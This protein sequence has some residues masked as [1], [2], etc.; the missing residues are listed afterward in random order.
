M[1]SGTYI[2]RCLIGVVVVTLL[3]RFEAVKEDEER[4]ELLLLLLVIFVALV[5]DTQLLFK[6]SEN[7]TKTKL[8]T[9]IL[10]IFLCIYVGM[11][12]L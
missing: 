10:F 12:N 11:T 5:V 9:N 7:I 1:S 6:M 3:D 4:I 8:T 2:T